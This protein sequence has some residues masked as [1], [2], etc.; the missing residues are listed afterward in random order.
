MSPRK[1]L[2]T[3]TDRL[4]DCQLQSDLNMATLHSQAPITVLLGNRKSNSAAA[5][6]KQVY[7]A[8]DGRPKF[9]GK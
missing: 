4:S 2:Y 5:Y 1:G 6:V 8:T 9:K 7:T 3:Q